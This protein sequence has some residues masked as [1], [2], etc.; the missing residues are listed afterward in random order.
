[1]NINIPDNPNPTPNYMYAATF[2]NPLIL[3]AEDSNAFYC[4]I[5][6]NTEVRMINTRVGGTYLIELLMDGVGGHTITFGTPFGWTIDG[7][8][9]INTDP[10][11]PN[12]ISAVT[13]YD[14]SLAYNIGNTT[15]V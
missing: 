13:L 14:D 15:A 10:D 5:T 11:A 9:T 4:L 8:D 12:I 2:A 6:G 7:S 3:D 1:M